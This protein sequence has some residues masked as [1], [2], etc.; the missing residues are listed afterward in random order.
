MTENISSEVVAGVQE[1]SLSGAFQDRHL[2]AMSC[3]RR[4]SSISMS[5]LGRSQ[6]FIS[7]KAGP[8]TKSLPWAS[9]TLYIKRIK[10]RTSDIQY[11]SETNPQSGHIRPLQNIL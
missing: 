3:K 6:T 9:H 5:R 8:I 4:L 1:T 10:A 2:K 7:P 11:R